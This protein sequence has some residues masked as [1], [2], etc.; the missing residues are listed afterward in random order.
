MNT[1]WRHKQRAA[2]DWSV[3]RLINGRVE[4]HGLFDTEESAR[5]TAQ[6]LN[7]NCGRVAAAQARAKM[8]DELFA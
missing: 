3:D 7:R 5:V 4:R 1:P 6:N 8:I 2:G